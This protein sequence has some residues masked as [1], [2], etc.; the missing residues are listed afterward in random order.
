MAELPMAMWALLVMIT[1]PMIDLAT[2]ALRSTCLVTAAHEAAHNAARAKSFLT[3]VSASDDSATTAA[4]NTV[5]QVLQRFSGIR[6]TSVV[7]N[8][9][10]TDTA[11]LQT[12]RRTT[13]LNAPADIVDNTYSLEVV[14]TA[15][16][17]P[18]IMYNGRMLGSIPGLSA[19]V[20]VTCAAQ[21]FSEYPAG[22]NQ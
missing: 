21:E 7:T 11:T 20:T 2:V 22:L 13:P 5:T 8:L 19:P 12:T 15:Q 6:S 9:V 3:P 18:L 17:S 10:I 4:Q 14:V 1:I 16:V